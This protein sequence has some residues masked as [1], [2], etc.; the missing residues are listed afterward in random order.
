MRP[1][2]SPGL[3]VVALVVKLPGDVDRFA[4]AGQQESG[5]EE[6]PG[7]AGDGAQDRSVDEG[8]DASP[9]PM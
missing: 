1:G 4:R 2:S 6:E 9:P 7:T 3:P 5:I 8:H